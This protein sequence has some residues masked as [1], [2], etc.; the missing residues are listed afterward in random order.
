MFARRAS[1]DLQ[2]DRR[3]R[4]HERA[5]KF[6]GRPAGDRRNHPDAELA[7]ASDPAKV[8]RPEKMP[9]LINPPLDL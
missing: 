4:G 2:V 1:C 9:D 6:T 8:R 3:M 5:Q 7:L